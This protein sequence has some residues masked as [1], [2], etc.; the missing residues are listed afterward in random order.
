MSRNGR[1]QVRDLEDPEKLIVAPVQSSTYAPAPA[2]AVNPD[3]ERLA[4]ALGQFGT[5]VNRL[6]A[7][8]KAEQ[9]KKDREAAMLKWQHY[10]AS[11]SNPEQ[12]AAVNA[13][14]IPYWHDPLISKDVQSYWGG[15]AAE[16]LGGE[17][18]KDIAEGK[19]KLGS[20]DFNPE[21]FVK[22]RAQGLIPRIGSSP[23]AMASYNNGVKAIIQKLDR[24]HKAVRGEAHKAWVHNSFAD[25]V[26]ATILR[27]KT[28]GQDGDVGPLVAAVRDLQKG[29]GP[30]ENGGVHGQEYKELDETLLKV[31]KTHADDV[32]M[33]GVIKGILEADRGALDAA[34]QKIPSLARTAK[35]RPTIEAI[36]EQMRVAQVRH[37]RMV[38]EGNVK[39]R[40]GQLFL[41]GDGTLGQ[42][43]EQQIPIPGGRESDVV[44][45]SPK[46]LLD[47]GAEAAVAQIRAE[48]KDNPLRAFDLEANLFAKNDHKHPQWFDEMER[49]RIAGLAPSE[50]G[51][52][53]IPSQADEIEKGARIYNDL[54][55]RGG[56]GYVQKHLSKESE[57]FY[58]AYNSLRQSGL[59]PVA[60]AAAV[61]KMEEQNKQ[62]PSVL[63]G[64]HDAVDRVVKS[65]LT[66]DKWGPFNDESINAAQVR[67]HITDLAT[68][69][70]RARG[71]DP[72]K[73][74]KEAGEVI[75]SRGFHYRNQFL[76]G[77]PGITE[78]DAPALDLVLKQK[79]E[80]YGEYFKSRG[81]DSAEG[82]AVA[83]DNKG[84]LHVIDKRTGFPVTAL[85]AQ[86]SEG[87]ELREVF[88]PI[89][90]HELVKAQKA[91]DKGPRLPKYTK[92]DQWKD[93]GV[94]G[95]LNAERE[96][97]NLPVTE[98]DFK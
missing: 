94:E 4:S 84:R 82:L 88:V 13:G 3:Y 74:V 97:K 80:R 87:N 58:E 66:D 75:R 31:L 33:H 1:V 5:Q 2:P 65:V 19:V 16:G 45:V 90:P 96:R 37:N 98:E 22:E 60:A 54:M 30:R 24:E 29:Y 36:Y 52:P 17:I 11:T 7:Q 62:D 85:E 76:V 81:I 14:E 86:D 38:I 27:A 51:Q 59:S 61:Q 64:T 35:L 89:M 34:G 43:P 77:V 46:Q 10:L 57:R 26:D 12:V 69:Y 93:R 55:A 20:N 50:M 83:P 23:Y 47:Q 72:E 73:A 15:K 71:M 91:V 53:H 56:S 63:R 28:L 40:A 21:Q 39:A 79:Y 8:Q 32:Q 68:I 44:K 92:P 9:E 48:N 67:R 95:M 41:R 70:V 18:D 49:G 6:A 25:R 42:M 78:K